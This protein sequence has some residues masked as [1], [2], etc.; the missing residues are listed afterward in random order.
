M[1]QTNRFI[2]VWILCTNR[3]KTQANGV[4]SCVLHSGFYGLRVIHK[5][6]RHHWLLLGAC[7]WVLLILMFASKFISFRAIDGGLSFLEMLTQHDWIILIRV[8]LLYFKIMAIGLVLIVGPCPAK[9]WLKA[10]LF[11]VQ[12]IWSWLQN[13]LIRYEAQLFFNIML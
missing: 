9:R 12:K 4:R 13:H 5:A 10:H 1:V 3:S 6:M 8:W 11:Q 7:G 2:K